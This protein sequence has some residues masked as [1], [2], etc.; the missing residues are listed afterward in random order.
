MANFV[1]VHGSWAG[2][3]QWADIREILAKGK[4]AFEMGKR[5]ILFIDEIHRFNKSQQDALLHAVE[6]G[7]VELEDRIKI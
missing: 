2:G 4:K 1:L 5:C 7:K 6:D 3:W